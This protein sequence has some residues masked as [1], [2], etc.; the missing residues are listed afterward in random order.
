MTPEVAVVTPEQALAAG[1]WVKVIG[2]AS[3]QDLEALE[4]LAGLFSLAG[5]HC[6]DVAA[7]AAVVAATRRGVPWALD[8]GAQAAAGVWVG[9]SGGGDPHL[10]KA[11]V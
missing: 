7:D 4:D 1:R 3:N 8:P 9:R 6:L 10:R 11:W 2:G 5:V